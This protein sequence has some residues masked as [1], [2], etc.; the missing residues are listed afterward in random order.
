M[1]WIKVPEEIMHNEANNTFGYLKAINIFKVVES[2]LGE[3]QNLQPVDIIP[4]F[5]IFQ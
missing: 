1:K 2:A 4:Y 3:M 5:K